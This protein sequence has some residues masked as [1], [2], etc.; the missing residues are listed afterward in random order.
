MINNSKKQLLDYIPLIILILSAII[1]WIIML[2]SNIII[3]WQHYAGPVF[4]IANIL[5]FIKNHQWGVL[6]SG[7]TLIL[8]MIGLLA[9]NVGI[10]SSYIYIKPFDAEIPLFIGNPI[11]LIWFILHLILSG[12][13]YFGIATKQYWRKLFHPKE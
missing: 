9:F 8:A 4:L 2:S 1:S 12:R 5:I 6:F 13:Y 11:N 10:I 7:L 3:Q